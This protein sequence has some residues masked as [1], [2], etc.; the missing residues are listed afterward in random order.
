MIDTLQPTAGKIS[1]A[2]KLL[3]YFLMLFLYLMSHVPV[4]AQSE[5]S[6]TGSVV[7]ANGAPIEYASVALQDANGKGIKGMLTD[8]LGRFN[9]SGLPH[10]KYAVKVTSMGFILHQSAHFDLSI[11]R[12]KVHLGLLKL[13][14][15]AQTLNAVN[16]SV[17]RK[18]IEQGLDKTVINIE[19][20]ILADGNNALELLERAPGVKVDEDGKISLK[21]RAGVNIMIN[22]KLTFLSP[23]EL[24]VM[25]KGTN[26]SSISKIEILANPSAK[27]DAAGNAGMINIVMKKNQAKG[28]NGS[29]SANG[30]AGR[31]ARYG[32]GFNLNYRND[33]VNVFGSYNYAFRGETE[34]LDFTRNFYDS[35]TITGLPNRVSDQH[36]KTNEPLNTHNFRVGMDWDIN[37]HNVLGILVNGNVGKYL[38]NSKTG[39]LLRDQTG[40]LISALQTTN[41]DQQS[42]KNITYNLNYLHKFKKESQTFSADADFASNSFTSN[43]N[44]DTYTLPN[45]IN[46]AGA[47]NKRKGYIPAK[48]DVYI[49][50]VD[51]ADLFGKSFKFET[52]LKSS[53]IYSDN[54][55]VYQSLQNE[56]WVYDATSSNHFKYREQIHAGYLNA[57]EEFEKFSIQLGLRAEYTN[58]LGNQISTG[59]SLKRDYFQLFPNVVINKPFGEAHQLQ[60]AYNKRIQRPDYSDLNPFRV[61][62]DP[63]L[64]YE[65]NPY[66]KPELTQSV[67][68]NYVYKGKYTASL[69]YSKTKD[70]ITW[71]TGQIDNINTTYESPQNLK[72]LI[73]YGISFTGQTNYFK[74][75]SATNFFN[76]FKNEYTGDGAIGNFSNSMW[77]YSFNSQNSFKAGK[78]Y[79]FEL[80]GYYN[81]KSVYGTAIEKGYYAISAAVQKMILKDKGSIKLLANDIFQGSQYRHITQY[82][83]IDM[84]SH[85]NV[86]SRRLMLSFSYRF[87]NSFQTRERKSSNEEE[88][89]RVKGN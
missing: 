19:N 27:Y 74:W 70:V 16:I 39:N 13:V 85:I 20:S 88:Q 69:N 10:G 79:S 41:Y 86:D 75:W 80:N 29:V 4:F 21:G 72:N 71:I 78:G 32:S 25:L 48:T 54:N 87:G 40:N 68:F 37:A 46:P 52:G 63:L 17:Q 58:T 36:T 60:L 15:D 35:G 76:V 64:Y 42:W 24:S 82:Q 38:H 6:V 22:G 55:L 31:K 28:W 9:F 50:K 30:G 49:A 83:N 53:L 89:N 1:A 56:N 51:Y 62:R 66:L 84:K 3:P 26:A 65:G 61:F 67:M 59:S 12:S 18:V 57:S 81:S 34:Y 2:G 5:T 11:Q 23:A 44:L 47:T 73:N 8:S 77:S 14:E 43:L 33:G 45:S 7:M